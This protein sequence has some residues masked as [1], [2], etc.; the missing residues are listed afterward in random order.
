MIEL[1]D[2]DGVI[3]EGFIE[4]VCA[5]EQL[6]AAEFDAIIEDGWDDTFPGGG[7]TVSTDTADPS[8]AGGLLQR[9][10]A[11][12]RVPELSPALG[13]R[14]SRQRSP[15]VER[16]QRRSEHHSISEHHTDNDITLTL[17]RGR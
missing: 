8:A 12:I 6:L 16:L 13:R 2:L 4:L 5:D 15:P 14:W 10:R 17:R 3:D 11:S 7:P 9:T 1:P